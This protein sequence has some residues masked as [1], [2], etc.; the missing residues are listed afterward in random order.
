MEKQSAQKA[1][2]IRLDN[3]TRSNNVLSIGGILQIQSQKQI[4]SKR[5]NLSTIHKKAG[6]AV[7]SEN[8]L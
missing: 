5:E 8:R 6:V 4:Q 1:D 3:K 7:L 2:V